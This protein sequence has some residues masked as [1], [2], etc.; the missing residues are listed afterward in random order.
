MSHFLDEWKN[1][2]EENARAVFEEDF[3]LDVTEKMFGEL[4]RQGK[5]KADLAASMNKSKAYVTQILNGS[6]NMTLRTLADIAYALDM[7]PVFNLSKD[8]EGWQ[9]I[10]VKVIP[11]SSKVV[12][13][14]KQNM[15]WCTA[16][17]I[18]F[19]ECRSSIRRAA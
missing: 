19:D 10:Q 3:I 11:S 13:T 12:A 9:T 4:E 15:Q 2:S 16:N 1:Q 18:S 17:V 8:G 7:K 14:P 5:T 6:R